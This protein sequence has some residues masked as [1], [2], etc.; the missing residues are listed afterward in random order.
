MRIIFITIIWKACKHWRS[1]QLVQ[2][3]LFSAELGDQLILHFYALSVLPNVRL[4]YTSN[5]RKFWYSWS[6]VFD[7]P[8]ASKI[9]ILIGTYINV[10]ISSSDQTFPKFIQYMIRIAPSIENTNGTMFPWN[11]SWQI[12]NTQFNLMLICPSKPTRYSHT[13]MSLTWHIQ[14]PLPN[15]IH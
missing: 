13:V 9:I 8:P 10:P 2:D 14:W 12:D 1:A 5:T 3:R 7:T 11:S 4:I 6:S 15:L